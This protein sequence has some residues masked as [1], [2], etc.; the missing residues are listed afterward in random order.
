MTI[1]MNM[2]L[3][4]NQ[5]RSVLAS[6]ETKGIS[7]EEL[8]QSLINQNF[9]DDSKSAE[10]EKWEKFMHAIN[11]F[12]EDFLADGRAQDYPQERESLE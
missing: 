4:D 3:T 6:A 7:V 8:L 5:L 2:N 12:T 9:P 10:D 11:G 1:T